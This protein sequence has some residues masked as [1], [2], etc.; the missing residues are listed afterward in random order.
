MARNTITEDIVSQMSKISFLSTKLINFHFLRLLEE[1]KPLPKINQNLFYQACCLI[2]RMQ[3]KEE[4]PPK[5]PELYESSFIMKRFLPDDVVLP[6]R[7]YLGA[8]ISNMNSMQVPNCEN[9]LKNILT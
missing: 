7:D 3:Y 6:T 9:H 8:Y 1:N 5:S 2:F 4:A